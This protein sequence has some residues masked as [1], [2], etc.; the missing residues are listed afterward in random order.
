[1]QLSD[2][3][4][5]ALCTLREFGPVRAVEVVQSP[6]MAGARK[7][8][9]QCHAMNAVTLAKL[10]AAGLVSVARDP[11][12]QPKDATGRRGLPRRVVTIS[13]TDAGCEA[14]AA[15]VLN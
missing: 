4:F 2:A 3:Q 12:S 6:N 14:L 10:E 5:G 1:M 8:K 7:V 9:L 11:L 13:I 15:N